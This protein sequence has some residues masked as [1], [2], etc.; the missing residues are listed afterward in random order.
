MDPSRVPIA[1]LLLLTLLVSGARTE[2][3]SPQKEPTAERDRLAGEVAPPG[4]AAA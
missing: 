3:D 4:G 1:L 2:E